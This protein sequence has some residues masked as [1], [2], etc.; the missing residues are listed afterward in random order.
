MILLPVYIYSN[1]TIIILLTIKW[2]RPRG[3]QE[4]HSSGAFDVMPDSQKSRECA[5]CSPSTTTNYGDRQQVCALGLF[6]P[7]SCCSSASIPRANFVSVPE[8][9]YWRVAEGFLGEV[10]RRAACTLDITGNPILITPYP[11]HFRST[12]KLL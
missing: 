3:L 1:I 10:R 11:M 4:G 8:R 6:Q 12:L 7:S 5:N 9:I 2:S